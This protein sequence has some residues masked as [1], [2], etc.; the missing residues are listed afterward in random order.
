MAGTVTVTRQPLVSKYGK[1]MEK[2]SVDW[3]SD[4]SGNATVVI[5]ELYGYVMK[6]VTDPGAAA[7]TANYDITLIDENSVDA[8]IGALIDRHTTTTEQVYP[9]QSGASTPVHVFGDHTFTVAN[10]GNAKNGTCVFY[11]V[12]CL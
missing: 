4:A 12:E 8:L 11:F 3:L 5:E 7:P 6:A 1:E 10:A 2:I 9:V